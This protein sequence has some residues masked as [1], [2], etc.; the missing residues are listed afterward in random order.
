MKQYNKLYRL[1]RVYEILLYGE[2]TEK[3]TIKKAVK[4]YG[5]KRTLAKNA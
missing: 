5:R 3:E 2:T 4:K 1:C